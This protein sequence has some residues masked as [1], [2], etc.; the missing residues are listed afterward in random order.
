[1]AVR[2][3]LRSDV[4]FCISDEHLVFFDSRTDSYIPI[5]I[6]HTYYLQAALS[7]CGNVTSSLT[8][9]DV[10]PTDFAA[11]VFEELVS[12]GLL[13]TNPV[14]GK[15]GVPFFSIAP[16]R[17]LMEAET[18]L[19]PWAQALHFPE[20]LKASRE[21]R[22]KLRAAGDNEGG[23]SLRITS[24]LFRSIRRR[25]K[26]HRTL[27]AAPDWSKAR[28]LAGV[29]RELR[30]WFNEKPVCTLDSLIVVELFARHGLFPDWTFGVQANPFHAHCWVQY[31]DVLINDTLDV[32]SQFT[33]IMAV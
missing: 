13:T 19:S 9:S 28:Y 2:Y 26:S 20:F 25:K 1:M 11:E 10:I 18:R 29:A 8:A 32:I 3:F 4:S 30:P 33:P 31:E 21:A 12:E 7:E 17:T 6:A 22:V 23:C 5:P 24:E 14:Q 16:T 27:T 15:K